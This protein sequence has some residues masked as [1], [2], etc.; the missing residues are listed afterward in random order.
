[1]ELLRVYHCCWEQDCKVPVI[2]VSLMN[3]PL[4]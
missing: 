2:F 1:M 4:A 3:P